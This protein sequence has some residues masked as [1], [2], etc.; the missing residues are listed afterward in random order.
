MLGQVLV[1]FLLGKLLQKVTKRFDR[2]ILISEEL[3]E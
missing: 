3:N 1:S 2:H